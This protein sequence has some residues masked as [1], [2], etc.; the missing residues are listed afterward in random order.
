[1][2][3]MLERAIAELASLPEDK[4]ESIACLIL[5]E[6]EA[7]RGWDQ[8]FAKSGGKLADMA[9]RAR[10]QHAAGETSPLAFPGE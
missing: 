2:N 4:Q 1:M 6:M 3:K 9:R 5:E 8:R 7:E 10:A